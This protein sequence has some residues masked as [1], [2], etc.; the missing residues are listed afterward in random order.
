MVASAAVR[1][2][3]AFSLLIGSAACAES[4]VTKVCGA[5]ED[6]VLECSR[7]EKPPRSAMSS[8]RKFCRV[9]LSYEHRP[10]DSPNNLAALTKSA[11][12]ECASKQ[13]CETF[14]SCLDRNQCQFFLESPSDTTLE[15]WCSPPALQSPHAAP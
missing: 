1:L 10:D 4:K 9:S 14:L 11:L 7:A 13:D 2:V 15:F 8:L 6:K 5:F 3:V 12:E